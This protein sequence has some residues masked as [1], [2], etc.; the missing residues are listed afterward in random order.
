[1][2]KRLLLIA[3]MVL[4]L[5]L[6]NGQS[7]SAIEKEDPRFAVAKQY[8]SDT[9][10]KKV[11]SLTVDAS[12]FREG[13]FLYYHIKEGGKKHYRLI[14]AKKSKVLELFSIDDSL[15][16]YITGFKEEGKEQLVCRMRGKDLYY[17][18]KTKSF[19]EIQKDTTKKGNNNRFGQREYWKSY[20]HDS[21][22]YM[23]GYL[24]DIYLNAAGENVRVSFDG[25]PFRSFTTFRTGDND[26]TRK[27]V[28]G[29]WH[30]NTNYAIFLRPDMR[31]VT[32]MTVVNSLSN[33]P[34]AKNYRMELTN[35][36]LVTQY[37]LFLLDAEARELVKIDIDRFR[38][39]E[40][41]L[42][43][44]FH[45]AHEYDKIY[46][47]RK[48]RSNDT[49]QLCDLDPVTR[50]VRVLVQ[51]TGVPIVNELLHSVLVMNGGNDIIWWSEREGLGAYYLYD[52][53][54][55]LKNKIAGGDFVAG[56]IFNTDTTGRRIVFEGY[57]YYK[58]R[59]P[60]EKYF[61][62]AKFDG[63]DFRCITP[64]PGDHSIEYSPSKSFFTDTYSTP[65]RFPSK[66]VRSVSGK[67]IA[68]LPAADTL[69]LL[70]YGW[71][72]PVPLE[73]LSADN[74]TKLY[75]VMYLPGE[76]APGQKF[77]VI[78]NM[79]PG[80]QTDLV[81]RSFSIDDNDNASLAR[82]GFVVINVGLK[83]SSPLRGPAFYG[84]SHGNLRDYAV[85]DLKSVVEQLAG[86][87]D[88]VDT[89]R[90][91]LYGHS[92]G[93][94]LTVTAMLKYPKFFKVGVS[95]SGNHDNNIYAKFWGETYN[96]VGPK[97][98][99]NMELADNLEGKLMLVTG[100]MDD[101]V[102]PA[103]TYRMV[104]AF[105]KADKRIDMFVIPG[106]DHNM[107]GNYYNKLIHHYFINNL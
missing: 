84:T 88:F 40:V 79:Y 4:S 101:N 33:P 96:G 50:K 32:E 19:T 20:S 51:E 102:H 17:S 54:G 49:L 43:R 105:I 12:W 18:L 46:F 73:L 60:Y 5:V 61:F 53:D 34:K 95:V 27:S 48:N 28:R 67:M 9:I 89:S 13:D 107:Y 94:F 30:G 24:H 99:T 58:E 25:E 1:M 62:T 59:N 47:T 64:S 23:Y 104:N 66:E 91:G 97:I 14:D 52:K 36:S 103:N 93:G 16:C 11:G 55:N 69:A 80:P 82:M 26:T 63:K 45:K 41:K 29:N 7:Y 81:P 77:P 92:G 83:G 35:D 76:I 70:N 98:K 44:N 87:Y 37:E 57:G 38:D 15:S 8:S 65:D 71:V 90:V 78:C 75:G 74:Q 3:G 72:K 106:A 68:R 21:S 85:D 39:Q 10:Y 86:K 100:D 22:F 42:I 6:V 2:G 31:S 56:K